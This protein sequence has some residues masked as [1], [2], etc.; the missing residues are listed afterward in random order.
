MREFSLNNEY[1][2]NEKGQ[3]KIAKVLNTN[4]VVLFG[5]TRLG[6]TTFVNHLQMIAHLRYISLGEITRTKI[7]HE[8]NECVASLMREW[9]EWPP[10]DIQ[11][12][13]S[14][15]IINNPN[16]YVLDGVPTHE[17]ESEWLV[18][19]MMERNGDEK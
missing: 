11:D 2:V 12:L 10:K 3:A 19:I 9:G 13:I 16:T 18:E 1:P 5:I 17:N 8:K 15:Y 4:D 6:K 7:M 14:P